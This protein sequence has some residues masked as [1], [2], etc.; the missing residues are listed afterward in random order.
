M[1]HRLLETTYY[2]E[3]FL[4]QVDDEKMLNAKAG[5]LPQH[6]IEAVGYLYRVLTLCGLGVSFTGTSHHG[7]MGEHQISH[8]I[9]CF[10]KE[11][12]SGSLHGQQV[13]VASLTMAR[14][15]QHFLSSEK[16]PV[17][18]KT[19]ID[20]EDMARRMGNNIAKQCYEEYQKKAFD[21]A[22]ADAFNQKISAIW[23]DLRKDAWQCP[24][25]LRKWKNC[26]VRRR[27]HQ[28]QRAWIRL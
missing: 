8:Y 13:G 23:D 15:Q 27:T 20:F 11:R 10:A 6:D 1:S 9:D 7:S 18:K 17:V 5:L 4:M 28:S 14:I 26:F 2:E 22:K 24:F 21:D 3:P 12:H 16:P 19:R 25:L